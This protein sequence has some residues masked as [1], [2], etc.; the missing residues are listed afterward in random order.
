MS[1]A[2]SCGRLIVAS[3]I[4]LLLCGCGESVT[5]EQVLDEPAKVEHIKGTDVSRVT[6]TRDA[7]GRIDLQTASVKRTGKLAVV[8]SGALL[9]DPEGVYWVYANPEPLV[10]VRREISVDHE[11]GSKAFISKGPPAGTRVVTVGVA[12][13]YGAET[14]VGH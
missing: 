6:L 2:R 10:F 3:I 13:L 8:P 7:A 11:T 1:R 12:E 9:I 14:E 5:D 4:G